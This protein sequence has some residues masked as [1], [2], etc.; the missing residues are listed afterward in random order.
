MATYV[1]FTPMSSPP[2][3]YMLALPALPARKTSWQLNTQI[4]PSFSRKITQRAKARTYGNASRPK[5]SNGSSAS[6]SSWP[7][8]TP[9]ATDATPA[10]TSVIHGNFLIVQ[11]ESFARTKCST[12][13]SAIISR[14]SVSSSSSAMVKERVDHVVDFFFCRLA[15]NTTWG[16][17]YEHHWEA[18]HE[19][20]MQ[21]STQMWLN[22]DAWTLEPAPERLHRRKDDVPHHDRGRPR[23]C[24]RLAP[25]LSD[26][27]SEASNSTDDFQGPQTSSEDED[28]ED[29]DHAPRIPSRRKPG[30]APRI[31]RTPKTPRTPRRPRVDRASLAHPTA[32][33]KAALKRR[34]NGAG[35]IGKTATVDSAV[36]ELKRLAESELQHQRAE[37]APRGVAWK[38]EDER[39]VALNLD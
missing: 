29:N 8:R 33:S 17:Y 36:R 10:R 14:C 26:A 13:S 37:L 12:P 38:A 19:A 24:R 11:T 9:R 7:Y 28:N 34:K 5:D 18:F 30:A 4:L 32:H 27:E 21:I 31:P 35:N 3:I 16:P 20:A 23:K 22:D 15:I 6:E 1:H 25:R 39:R 2:S